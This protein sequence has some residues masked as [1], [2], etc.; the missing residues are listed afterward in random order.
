[1][2]TT[3]DE[4]LSHAKEDVKTAIKSLSK[5]LVDECCGHDDFSEEFSQ[6][7]ELAFTKLR[8]VDKMLHNK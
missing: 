5:I 4:H 1:M 8:N 2:I 6:K 7:L 3:A